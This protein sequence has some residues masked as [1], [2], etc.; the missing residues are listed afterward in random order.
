MATFAA[1]MADAS[2]DPQALR[3]RYDLEPHDVRAALRALGWGE[4][5]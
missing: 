4:T 3:D 5:A 1:F 2:A